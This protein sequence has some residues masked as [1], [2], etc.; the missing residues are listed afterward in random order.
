ML[1]STVTGPVCV[2]KMC[3]AVGNDGHID[4]GAFKKKFVNIATCEIATDF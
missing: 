2:N 3:I 4:C 1:K